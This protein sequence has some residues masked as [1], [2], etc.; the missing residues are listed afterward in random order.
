MKKRFRICLFLP[1]TK[2]LR[3]MLKLKLGFNRVDGGFCRENRRCSLFTVI[4]HSK[5]WV[6]LS[7]NFKP[8]KYG[9]YVIHDYIGLNPGLSLC[10][11]FIYSTVSERKRLYPSRA[12]FSDQSS[13]YITV[14]VCTRNARTSWRF[15]TP[16]VTAV[17]VDGMATDQM[18]V[19]GEH[20]VYGLLETE[21][22]S[23]GKIHGTGD[24]NQPQKENPTKQDEKKP[25]GSS[26]AQVGTTCDAYL[27]VKWFWEYYGSVDTCERR[28][29][30]VPI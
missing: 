8:E 13:F 6:I 25:T 29:Q 16:N 4:V 2:V 3:L 19:E 9:G 14:D 22:A 30:F 1:S 21:H 15:L 24:E 28:L 27:M 12:R 26:T 17:N 11:S 23:A 10:R 18:F 20:E 7:L 5:S